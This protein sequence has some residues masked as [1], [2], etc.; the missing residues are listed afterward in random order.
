MAYA[1]PKVIAHRGYWETAGSAQNSLTSFAKAN[2]IGAFGSEFDVWFTGDNQLVVN[3]DRKHEGLDMETATA[4]EVTA[5]RLPNGENIPTFDQYLA[6]AQTMP[7]TRV[8]LEMK[9]LRDLKREDMAAAAIVEKLRQYDVLDR[10]D[11]ICFSINACLAFKK[12]VPDNKIYYLDGDLTPK[13]IKKL[14]LAGIDYSMD[15]LRKNPEWVADAHKRG[16]EVNVW[17]VDTP[18]DMQYFID[19]GVDYITTDHPEELQALISKK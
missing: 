7:D 17:T 18:E 10:T 16:L 11:I 15:A 4:N 13:K 1:Q 2:A 6:Q 12:L 19:L 14:G 3:H 9:S 5:L 8:I